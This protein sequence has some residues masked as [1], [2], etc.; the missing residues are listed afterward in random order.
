MDNVFVRLNE[1]M[2][3]FVERRKTLMSKIITGIVL[4]IPIAF[5]FAIAMLLLNKSNNIETNIN[6]I[7]DKKRDLYAA[8]DESGTKKVNLEE[9]TKNKINDMFNEATK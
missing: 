3:N 1:Q 9:H 2:I 7:K 4:F 8:R 6:I 5:T